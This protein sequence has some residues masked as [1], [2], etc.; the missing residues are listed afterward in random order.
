VH[1]LVLDGVYAREADGVLRF[2]RL[3]PP[4]TEEVERLVEGLAVAAY[5]LTEGRGAHGRFM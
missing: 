5:P 2:H 3:P 1:A 4:T